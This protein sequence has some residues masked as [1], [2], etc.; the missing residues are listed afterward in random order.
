MG[1]LL[2]AICKARGPEAYEFFLNVFLPSQNWPAE[3]ALDFTTS[4]RDMDGK[5][6]R[7]YFTELIRS[8]R[9]SS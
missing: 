5:T 9:A 4:L 3:M 1:N 7:K 8:S 6:F 2:Q